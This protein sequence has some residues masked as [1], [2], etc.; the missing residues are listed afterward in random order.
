MNNTQDYVV[1]VDNHNKKLG[2]E[3]K[4]KA[5][6][7][8]KLHRA[9]SIFVFNSKQ[10][11]LIQQRAKEKY[12]CPMIW[13]NT[14]CSH[15][16]PKESYEKAIHRRLIEE[17][18]FD[19]VLK[20]KFCFIYKVKFDNGLT[21]NEYDCIFIGKY[22]DSPKPNP[23]EVM[24]FRWISLNDLKKD[25]EKYQKKYAEWFKIALRKMNY[26]PL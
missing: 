14:V 11:L 21:E 24:D 5:H 12:H 20:K 7:D 8:G 19:C 2:V 16:R 3:E 4:M 22:D 9:F 13:A 10:E 25:I 1:L 15:P 23:S 6:I 17:M 18:G 26:K